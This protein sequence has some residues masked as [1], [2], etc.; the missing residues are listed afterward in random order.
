LYVILFIILTRGVAV[1]TLL[2]YGKTDKE[3]FVMMEKRNPTTKPIWIWERENLKNYFDG[4]NSWV[5]D[6]FAFRT[7]LIQY[8]S[9]FLY[10]GGVSANPQK[11]IVGKNN[12]LFLG[13]SFDEVM[14]QVTG[15]I[16]FNKKQL[17]KWKSSFQLRAR[18]LDLMGIPFYAVLVPKKHTVYPEYLPEYIIPAKE[19][20]FDQIMNSGPGFDLLHLKDTL[21]SSKPYWGNLLYNKTDSHWSEIGAYISYVKIINHLKADFNDLASIVLTRDD[22][23]VKPHPGV[24]NK[25]I[26]NLIVDMN[27]YNVTIIKP[28]NWNNQI[29]KT[30]YEGDTLPSNPFDFVYYHEKVIIHNSEKKYTLLVFEDSFSV[31][32]SAF[33]NQTFGKIIYCHYSEPEAKEFTQLV[34]RF[35]P[36]LVLYEFGEQSL[37][38]HDL[39]SNNLSVKLAGDNFTVL[40]GK[41]GAYFY[42]QL[43]SYYQITNINVVDSSL[44]FQSRGNDPSFVLPD[45]KLAENKFAALKIDFSIPEQTFAQIFYLTNQNKNFNRDQSLIL[46]AEKGRNVMVFYFPEKG[47]KGNFIRFDPGTVTGEYILHSIEVMQDIKN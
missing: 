11:I 25:F 1:S 45:M 26:L 41:N 13:N 30:N 33:L 4:L 16:H 34:E 28:D 40:Y 6:N 27:D 14:D 35:K 5:N 38:L 18:Y 42:D 43:K 10:L 31:R 8:Y 7:L 29:V 9:T 23:D 39:A 44:R 32:L 20:V 36:D 47:V 12:Y 17:T 19:N 3:T 24:Q 15:K 37:A 21:I 22:F 2:G 46:Q